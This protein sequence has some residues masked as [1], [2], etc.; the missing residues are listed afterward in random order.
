MWKITPLFAEWMASSN[1]L[2]KHRILH[3]QSTI[4]ELGSGIAGLVGLVTAPK[5]AR[6][7]LTDQEYA[8][9]L[10]KR[11]IETNT[12]AANRKPLSKHRKSK[13]DHRG[14]PGSIPEV[15]VLDW[16]ESS[17]DDLPQ[18]LG[19][20]HSTGSEHDEVG[21]DAVIACD[22]IYNENLIEPFVRTCASLCRLGRESAS[23]AHTIC[24]IV[25]QLRTPDI[26]QTWLEVMARSF[27]VWRMPEKYLTK[28]LEESSG[29]TVHV[30]ILRSDE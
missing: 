27:R 11:N 1:L 15:L 28:G 16:E 24:L 30:A 21:L 25:Q 20:T 12:Q 3:D 10:L 7:I 19:F 13:S 18:V 6:Y 4:L 17:L 5:V 9:K 23:A 22:C 26:F 8:L 14:L 29:F 2:F